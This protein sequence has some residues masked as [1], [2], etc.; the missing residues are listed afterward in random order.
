MRPVIRIALVLASI[1][2][3]FGTA[4]PQS[5]RP[6]PMSL[7][8]S[9]RAFA[10]DVATLGIRDGFLAHLAAGSIVFAAGPV[11]GRA[12]YEARPKNES[13]LAW[14]PVY[15]EISSGGDLGWTTG[16]WTFRS[17]EDEPIAAA[18]H[19][20]SLW[21]VGEDGVRRVELD[22]GIVHEPVPKPTANPEGRVLTA[23]PDPIGD[24]AGGLEEADRALSSAAAL[25]MAAAYASRAASDI[26]VYRT[27]SPSATGP[28][29]IELAA[30]R[31]A[32]AWEPVGAAASAGGDLGYTYG[33]ARALRA[34]PEADPG[35]YLR[36]WRRDGEAAWRLALDLAD[37]PPTD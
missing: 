23:G 20:V 14:D 12:S 24:P 30:A 4:T 8:D 27:G 19:Y 31:G 10:R 36:I 26:R 17:G 29:A 6:D 7:V 35:G 22:V 32:F 9:E 34:G 28:S 5:A 16:P 37:V 2:L 11:D 15:A 1:P 13:K 33:R 18:G 3:D 21:R 25:D